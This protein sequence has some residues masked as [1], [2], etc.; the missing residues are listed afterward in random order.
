KKEKYINILNDLLLKIDNIILNIKNNF[1]IS[2]NIFMSDEEFNFFREIFDDYI[3]NLESEK[4]NA[5][6]LKSEIENHETV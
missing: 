4:L 6:K 3:E 5:E 2:R 1:K